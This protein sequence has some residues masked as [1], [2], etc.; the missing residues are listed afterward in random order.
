[1]KNLFF[2]LTLSFS[3]FVNAEVVMPRPYP[4]VKNGM[5]V[6]PEGNGRKEISKP[7]PKYNYD[8]NTDQIQKIRDSVYDEDVRCEQERCPN[9]LILKGYPYHKSFLACPKETPLMDKNGKCYSC[10]TENNQIELLE[11]YDNPCPGRKTFKPVNGKTL[12]PYPNKIKLAPSCSTDNPLLIQEGYYARC[13]DCNDEFENYPRVISKKDCDVCTNRTYIS[14]WCVNGTKEKPLAVWKTVKNGNVYAKV[15]ENF[16]CDTDEDIRMNYFEAD[17]CSMVCPNRFRMDKNTYP[18][19]AYCIKKTIPNY[20]RSFWKKN[21][22]IVIL[23]GIISLFLLPRILR[24]MF[25]KND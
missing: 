11:N 24:K 21:C 2:L 25:A 10:D 15:K 19:A 20:I 8:C 6:Y 12:E 23:L 5:V 18:V 14:G 1:M 9:R 22:F 13:I 3:V 4:S 16:S 7:C 17:W